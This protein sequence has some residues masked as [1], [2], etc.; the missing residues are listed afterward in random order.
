[1]RKLSLIAVLFAVVLGLGAPDSAGAQAE[2]GVG[3]RLLDAPT[4]RR[5]DPRARLYIVDHV[6]PGTTISR[7]IEIS[8]DTNEGFAIDA[9]AGAASVKD[10]EFTFG[11][12]DAK[13]ELTSWT[14]V[15]PATE[16]YGPGDRK[17]ATVT[18]TVPDKASEGERYAVVWASVSAKAPEGGGLGAVN[19]VGVRIYLSVGPGGEP[20]SD[21]EVTA[22][23]AQRTKDGKPQVAAVVENTGGRALDLSGE[24]TL[25]DG[26]GGLAA[27]PFN[28]KVGTTLGVGDSGPVLVELDEAVPNGPWDAKLV[29][30][31]GLEEREVTATITFPKAAGASGPDVKPTRRSSRGGV[32]RGRRAARRARRARHL[33]GRSTVGLTRRT[34]NRGRGPAPK[35]GAPGG[36]A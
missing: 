13:N 11:D 2:G 32:D 5:D 6:A 12:A 1:M 26:P 10:G 35:L 27:G 8:N 31:A 7:R 15:D 4:N 17:T 18:I 33:R 21:F 14:T 23:R 19:R 9:Y 20:P 16:I 3:I 36:V 22:L 24:L 29:M 30:K 25:S 34:T 28:A